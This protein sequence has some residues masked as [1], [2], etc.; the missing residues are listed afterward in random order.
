MSV[1]PADNPSLEEI[2]PLTGIE[3][4]IS[5][6]LENSGLALNA[7]FVSLCGRPWSPSKHEAFFIHQS[8]FEQASLRGLGQ[9]FPENLF[10]S[11]N[12]QGGENTHAFDLPRVQ[13]CLLE[14]SVKAHP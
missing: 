12:F 4:L 11:R 8:K 6:F 2:N 1:I 14:F 9:G 7:G 3:L 10:L 5:G 13:Y